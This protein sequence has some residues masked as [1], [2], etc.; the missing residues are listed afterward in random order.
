MQ[1]CLGHVELCFGA[2]TSE[3]AADDDIEGVG[4]A[5]AKVSTDIDEGVV[6]LATE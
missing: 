4:G 1:V 2:N 5:E 3:I 6:E